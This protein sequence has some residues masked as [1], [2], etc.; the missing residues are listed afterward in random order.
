MS[1]PAI[2]NA[3]GRFIREK[4]F[5]REG[6][7]REALSPDVPLSAFPLV[8]EVGC[9]NGH[10]LAEYARLF[11]GSDCIGVDLKA[12]RLARA[13]RK[14]DLQGIPNL[15]FVRGDVFA[16]LQGYF[17]DVSFARIFINFPDPWPKYRHR[18]HRLNHPARLEGLLAH[19]EPGGEFIW[20][21]DYYPQIVDVLLLMQ[22]FVR[23][24]LFTNAFGAKGYG[25]G[26]AGY[27]M[28]LYEKRWRAMGRRIYYIKFIRCPGP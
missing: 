23:Q 10:F 1:S 11:P 6:V 21:C 24:G 13:C 12:G 19:L 16:L 15:R 20:V 26:I 17:A 7:S 28:T 27:P 4:A 9:G 2:L 14:A 25:E 5:P 22:P 18:E 8:L 3:D